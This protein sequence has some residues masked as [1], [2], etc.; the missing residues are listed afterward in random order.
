MGWLPFHVTSNRDPKESL[1]F[2]NNNKTKR[3]KEKKEKIK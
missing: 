2:D 3:E 1:V